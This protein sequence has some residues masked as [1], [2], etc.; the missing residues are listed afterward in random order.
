M[1]FLSFTHFHVVPCAFHEKSN[2]FRVENTV[3]HT[4]L[5]HHHTII[6]VLVIQAS[7]FHTAGLV[8]V[9]IRL[10]GVSQHV[11]F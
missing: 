7:V 9:M 11:H 3:K 5:T 6:E 8:E 2:C 10:G 4:V 1:T